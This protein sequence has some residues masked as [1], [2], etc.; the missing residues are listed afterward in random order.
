MTQGFC[1]TVFRNNEHYQMFANVLMQQNIWIIHYISTL[2]KMHDWKL[3]VFSILFINIHSIRLYNFLLMYM[4]SRHYSVP[5][6]GDFPGISEFEGEVT[7]SHTY[8]TPEPYANK[9]VL[10]S[11]GGPSGIDITF[12]IAKFA[13]KVT[14]LF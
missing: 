4:F 9:T 10:V 1:N 11:G 2:C 8:R 14:N 7:H 12:D 3:K 5:Y 6:T 13:S